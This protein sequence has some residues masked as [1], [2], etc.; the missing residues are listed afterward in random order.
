M[1]YK[2]IETNRFYIAHINNKQ[3]NAGGED[4]MQAGAYKSIAFI[5]A[6]VNKSDTSS[7]VI[8]EFFFFNNFTTL[9]F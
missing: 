3:A 6:D 2:V 1:L 7:Y 9:L 5:R 4:D 8:N